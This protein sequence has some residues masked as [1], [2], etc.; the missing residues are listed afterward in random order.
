MHPPSPEGC[1]GRRGGM[2]VAVVTDWALDWAWALATIAR[3]RQNRGAS[4]IE[5]EVSGDVQARLLQ[6][7]YA[8]EAGMGRQLKWSAFVV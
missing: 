6:G 1:E 7:H 4:T 2:T 5:L 8:C 3:T